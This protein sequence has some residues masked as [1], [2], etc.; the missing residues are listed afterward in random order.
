M[1]P[2]CGPVTVKKHPQFKT[3]YCFSDWW[4][5]YN[6]YT[7]R[8]TK[9]NFL[10]FLRSP[11]WGISILPNRPGTC[12]WARP[13]LK[14]MSQGSG[15]VQQ[16]WNFDGHMKPC[17]ISLVNQNPSGKTQA[18]IVCEWT[19]FSAANVF[20]PGTAALHNEPQWKSL[21][22]GSQFLVLYPHCLANTWL[23][24]SIS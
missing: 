24:V 16:E 13:L 10:D 7:P 18:W 1:H 12:T 3:F 17:S 21:F 23:L 6:K 2:I 19:H 11:F 4:N 14:C 5:G 22:H 15:R 20:F 9:N 8:A